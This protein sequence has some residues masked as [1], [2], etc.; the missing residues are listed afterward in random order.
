MDKFKQ[1]PRSHQAAEAKKSAK[2]C[3]M[4]ERHK[5]AEAAKHDDD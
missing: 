2:G 4:V 3:T 5:E 1:M